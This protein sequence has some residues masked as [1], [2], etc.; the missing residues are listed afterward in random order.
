MDEPKELKKGEEYM[1]A[2]FSI[3][4]EKYFDT[5]F[6]YQ[7][8]LFTEKF[9]GQKAQFDERFNGLE[10]KFDG[11]FNIID[12]RFDSLETKFD[13][14]INAVDKK[15]TFGFSLIMAVLAVLVALHFLGH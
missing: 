11:K 10:A 2:S 13:E 4:P 6:D 9:N 7:E 12:E 15:L 1:N 14:K 8:K 5:R 3:S